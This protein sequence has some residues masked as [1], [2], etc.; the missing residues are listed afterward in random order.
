MATKLNADITDTN[1]EAVHGRGG[2][3]TTLPAALTNSG[4][5]TLSEG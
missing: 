1:Y 5:L 3:G 2:S 4:D